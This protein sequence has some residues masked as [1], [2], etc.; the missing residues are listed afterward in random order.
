MWRNAF[1]PTG[2]R[3]DVWGESRYG[4]PCRECA[5]SWKLDPSDADRITDAAPQ[6]FGTLFR[7][8][9]SSTSE[10]PGW[11]ALGYVWHVADNFRIWAERVIAAA[12]SRHAGIVTYDPD[13]LAAARGYEQM[14]LS[15]ALWS[16]SRG[17]GDWQVARPIGMEAQGV[18]LVHPVD[19]RLDLADARRQL[20]HEVEHHI[21]DVRRRFERA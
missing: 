13:A 19:G 16:L 7:G 4:E 17:V 14:T 20:A 10:V 9:I 3:G 5:F 2:G 8:M 1:E 11:S 12:L 21:T 6:L 15:A 18:S